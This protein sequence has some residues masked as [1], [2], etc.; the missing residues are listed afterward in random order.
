[1]NPPNQ[2]EP[3]IMERLR[4]AGWVKATALPQSPKTITNLIDW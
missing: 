4:G 3:Q 2:R 1:M